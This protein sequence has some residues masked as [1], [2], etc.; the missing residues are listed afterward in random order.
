[1]KNGVGQ[2][3]EDDFGICQ[4]SEYKRELQPAATLW[5]E[6]STRKAF[7]K[8]GDQ[9]MNLETLDLF[10]GTFFFAWDSGIVMSTKKNLIDVFWFQKL[11]AQTV[12]DV[13]SFPMSRACVY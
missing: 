11:S 7:S 1:M 2:P 6:R 5:K 13:L 3:E 4:F 9:L 12:K 8:L 10:N